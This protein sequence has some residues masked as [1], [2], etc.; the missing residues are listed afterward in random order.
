[1]ID[2]EEVP[3]LAE[4]AFAGQPTA[5]PGRPTARPRQVSLPSV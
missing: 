4:H 1:M 5:E 2:D 3:E